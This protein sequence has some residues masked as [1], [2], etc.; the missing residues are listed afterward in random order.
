MVIAHPGHEIAAYHFAYLYQPLIYCLTDGSS[1]NGNP[2]HQQCHCQLL[3][4]GLQGYIN[5]DSVIKESD[6]YDSILNKDFKFWEHIIFSLAKVINNAQPEIIAFD[7]Y[8]GYS[9]IHDLL[10][11]CIFCASQFFCTEHKHTQLL[12]IKLTDNHYSS[13]RNSY[14]KNGIKTIYGSEQSIL[15]KNKYAVFL[16][17]YIAEIPYD[18]E[19]LKELSQLSEEYIMSSHTHNLNEFM[20]SS[21]PFYESHAKAKAKQ[22]KYQEAIEFEKH[23]M[24]LLKQIIAG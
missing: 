20:F 12:E 2:R 23:I 6:I 4:D 16:S 17:K 3:D 13:S 18:K 9:P 14:I 10:H 8:E 1:G 22:G 11:A 21:T 24:P 19:L 5:I 7:A 15:K